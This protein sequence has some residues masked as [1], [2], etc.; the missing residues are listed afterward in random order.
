MQDIRV[1]RRYDRRT[2]IRA[3]GIAGAA[4]AVAALGFPRLAD[5]TPAGTWTLYAPLSTSGVT[6]S[7]ASDYSGHSD[8][9]LDFSGPGGTSP[10]SGTPVR[11]YFNAGPSYVGVARI[12][13]ANGISC[14]TAYFSWHKKVSFDL[15]DNNCS[16]AARVVSS[17]V[18]SH[19]TSSV[20]N[21]QNYS[22]AGGTIAY[23][24][25]GQ[26]GVTQPPSSCWTGSHCH[27]GALQMTKIVSWVGQCKAAGAGVTGCWD[28]WMP[29]C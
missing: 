28:R 5:A 4:S 25:A 15:K 20:S 29:A 8:N 16:G 18:A 11:V 17:A 7:C 12:T 27:F 26:S 3:A 1:A 13:N 23:I 2:V 10:G 14:S 21:G 19:V 6:G 24:A 9:A 22:G